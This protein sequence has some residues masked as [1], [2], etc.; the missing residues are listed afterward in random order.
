MISAADGD[1]P[2]GLGQPDGDRLAAVAGVRYSSRIRESRKT[3]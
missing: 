2:G 1:D 3:S